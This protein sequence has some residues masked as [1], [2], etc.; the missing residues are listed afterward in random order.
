MATKEERVKLLKLIHLS[1][2]KIDETVK[3]ESLT[4]LLAEI[5]QYVLKIQNNN[6]IEKN[7]AVLLY[8]LASKMKAQYKNRQNFLVENIVNKNLANDVQ[9][10]GS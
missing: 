10:N 5:I 2:Q 9:L 1:D 6:V 8:T 7:A 4:A 3:N